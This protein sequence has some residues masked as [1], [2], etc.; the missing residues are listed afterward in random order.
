MVIQLAVHQAIS[1]QFAQRP[2]GSL[3]DVALAVR[4]WPVDWHIVASRA[5]SWR[6]GTAVWQV[7]SLAEALIGLSG[8]DIALN[9]L[10]PSPMRRRLL[11]RFVNA[12]TIVAAADWRQS[13]GRQ[14]L[15]L[16]LVDRPRDMVRL[17]GRTVWP[18]PEWLAARYGPAASRSR[19]LWQIIRFGEA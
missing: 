9:Q 17:M 7:L 12:E 11:R 1:S 3:L 13:Y 15:L 19:H 8:V 18:E 2:L 4:R 5:Q 10:R 16:A 14:L 6:V